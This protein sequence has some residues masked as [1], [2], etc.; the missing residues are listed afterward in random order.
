V[1]DLGRRWAVA[2]RMPWVTHLAGSRASWIAL[3]IQL[4]NRLRSTVFAHRPNL[5]WRRRSSGPRQCDRALTTATLS[6][7]AGND[8]VAA[9]PICAE[10]LY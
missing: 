10:R 9:L 3:A 6:S 7:G 4:P 8:K 2:L 1:A 5:F